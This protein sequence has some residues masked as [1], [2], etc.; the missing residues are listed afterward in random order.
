MNALSTH[1]ILGSV[2]IFAALSHLACIVLMLRLK[3]VSYGYEDEN[4]SHFI[5]ASDS[6]IVSVDEVHS[7]LGQRRDF[8]PPLTTAGTSITTTGTTSSSSGTSSGGGGGAPST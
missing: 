3:K 1:P 2:L 8:W 7:L 4:G 6:A 5:S